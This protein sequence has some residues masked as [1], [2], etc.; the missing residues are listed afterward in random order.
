M[1]LM[2]KKHVRMIKAC[3]QDPK[4]NVRFGGTYS[5]E[6][7]VL[8]GLRQGDTLSLV[9]L[10]ITLDRGENHSGETSFQ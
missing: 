5:N 7:S 8:T 9:S 4:F 3:V 6:F 10:K 2:E 1:T